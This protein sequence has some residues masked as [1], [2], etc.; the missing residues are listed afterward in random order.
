M[1][2]EDKRKAPSEKGRERRRQRE[3]RLEELEQVVG[4][5]TEGSRERLLDRFL[6]HLREDGA[7]EDL[8]VATPGDVVSFLVALDETGKTT[9]HREGCCWWGVEK[10]QKAECGCP[11]RAGAGSVNTTRGRLQGLFRDAGFTVPWD[12]R[13]QVGNPCDSLQ[14]KKYVEKVQLEQLQGGVRVQQAALIHI[15]LF[16]TLMEET[17][18]SWAIE[19]YRD[20]EKALEAALEATFYALAWTTGMRAQDAL[21]VSAAQIQRF[22]GGSK[23]EWILRT[24]REKA[25]KK[26]EDGRMYKLQKGPERI[27]VQ[28]AW[29]AVRATLLR[30]GLEEDGKA[31]F[32]SPKAGGEGEPRWGK[33]WTWAQVS[34]KFASRRRSL[35]WPPDV[36]LHSFH[37]SRAWRERQDGVPEEATCEAMGWSSQ[38]YH[39]YTDDRVAW[40]LEDVERWQREQKKKETGAVDGTERE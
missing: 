38:M 32:R 26:A 12:P 27:G 30:T 24:G 34:D 37:G 29:H 16:D 39:H 5:G 31:L 25:A 20:P 28:Q 18:A 17:M 40:K 33:A 11:K 21:R 3:R 10:R 9:V 15:S 19:E 13:Y 35:D 7:P 8:A 2:L 1:R 23:E 36:T 22:G 14:A 4:R 6:L